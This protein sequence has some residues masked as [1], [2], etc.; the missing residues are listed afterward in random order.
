MA[1]AEVTPF[2][3][4]RRSPT[5]LLFEGGERIGV[6]SFI[7]NHEQ[8]QGP[9]L[10]VHPYPELF[11]VQEG[12]GRFTVGDSEVEVT[13]GHVLVVPAETQHGFKNI[14]EGALRVVSVHPA[15]KVE[16]TYV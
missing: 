9:D 1:E 13:G 5:A 10:H 3:E 12:R 15:S 11:I 7:T 8:G 14:G 16:Q 4:L 2:E 6:S